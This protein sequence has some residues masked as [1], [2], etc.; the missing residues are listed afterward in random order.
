MNK[1]TIRKRIQTCDVDNIPMIELIKRIRSKFNV[2]LDLAKDLA[3][4]AKDVDARKH[5]EVLWN[6]IDEAS[7]GRGENRELE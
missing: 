2:G 4:E 7:G 5:A 6:A 1:K 3:Y